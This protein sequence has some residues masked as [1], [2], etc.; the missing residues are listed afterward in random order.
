MTADT[1]YDAILV[2]GPRDGAL[3]HSADAAVVELE[4]D[5]FIHRYVVTT[6]QRESDGGSYTVYNYDGE[7]DPTGA[8]PGVETPDGGHHTPIREE[9]TQDN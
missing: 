5:G 1:R 3:L 8:E 4:I 9:H 7:I 2:G 6:T